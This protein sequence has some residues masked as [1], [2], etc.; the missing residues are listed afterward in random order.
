MSSTAPKVSTTSARLL[1]SNAVS[2]RPAT[3]TNGDASIV[4]YLSPVGT[5]LFMTS[6]LDDF[7]CAMGDHEWDYDY[8]YNYDGDP[9]QVLCSRRTCSRCSTRHWRHEDR[10][11]DWQPT[12]HRD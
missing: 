6:V 3:A 12:P 9:D 5:T 8:D 10:S 7:R 1:K 4:G 11:D 2:V